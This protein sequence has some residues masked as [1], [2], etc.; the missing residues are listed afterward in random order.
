MALIPPVLA[1]FHNDRFTLGEFFR[2]IKENDMKVSAF[3]V[4]FVSVLFVFPMYS[5]SASN[6]H[7]KLEGIEGESEDGRPQPEIDILS[8]SWGMNSTGQYHQGGG[9]GAGKVNVMDLHFVKSVDKSTPL[10]INYC[11][12]GKPIPA[13]ML[14][15][16]R[17]GEHEPYVTIE[18][19]K[20]LVSSVST[21]GSGS[22][23]NLTENITLN[24]ESYKLHYEK[25]N[26]DGS[27][28]SVDH[29]WNI[30]QNKPD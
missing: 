29:N 21:G 11:A 17:A 24:F 1:A 4:L 3:K 14:T 10:L 12:T 5:F 16:R 13:A 20:I 27:K 26:P 19:K 6:Q 28:N 9:G 8:W 25:Q 18:L 15:L 7:I 30:K 23:D 2:A 22:E